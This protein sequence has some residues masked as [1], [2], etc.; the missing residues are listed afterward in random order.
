MISSTRT[1]ASAGTSAAATIMR[2]YSP[3]MVAALGRVAVGITY[4]SIRHAGAVPCPLHSGESVDTK[5]TYAVQLDGT[6]NLLAA[7]VGEWFGHRRRDAASR[8]AG[9][10]RRLSLQ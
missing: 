3:P 4:L 6:T 10:P 1:D 5:R 8:D 9:P 7:A 2:N